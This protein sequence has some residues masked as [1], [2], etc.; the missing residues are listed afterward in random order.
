MG[1]T[2]VP[3]QHPQARQAA[4]L[5]SPYVHTRGSGHP[6]R[7][8][9]EGPAA[10]VRLSEPGAP[11][12][13]APVRDRATFARLH[14][15]RRRSRV[16]PVSAVWV[17]G[18]DGDSPRVAYAVSRKVGGAV[19][20]NRTRRRLRAVVRE[21]EPRLCPGA[22]LLSAGAAA[23]VVAYPVLRDAVRRAVDEASSTNPAPAPTRRS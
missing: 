11:T 2:P 15:S 21:L 5:S 19:A 12:V 22:Y 4:R 8:P 3:A 18:R 7:P 20:R 13:T 17:P 23:R 16:G 1:E 6:C 14:V 10:A 9:A